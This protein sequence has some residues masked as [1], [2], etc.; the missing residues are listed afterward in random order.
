MLADHKVNLLL[1]EDHQAFREMLTESLEANG[2]TV[3]AYD[4]AEAALADIEHHSATIALLDINLPGE[5]GL[6][7]AEQLRQK[8]PG[9]GIIMLTVR[10]AI[11]DKLAGYDSGADIYLPKPIAPE[12]LDAAI[13]ALN[14]RLNPVQPAEL[15]LYHGRSELC[16]QSEAESQCVVL[17]DE[18]IRLFTALALAP[19]SKLEFWQLAEK[20]NLD[21]DSNALRSNLE[22]R[23]SRLRQKLTHLNQPATA[24]KAIRGFGYR[25]T[26]RVRIK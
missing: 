7:L 25:L 8:L 12:E 13:K 10:N 2:H 22:K 6:Y 9:L 23:V 16:A 17:T 4:S 5:D 15:I 3:N 20:L 18:E 1:V 24:I 14:R 21:L 26:L 19:Q 11:A